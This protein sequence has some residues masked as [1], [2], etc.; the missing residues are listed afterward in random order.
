VA[1]LTTGYAG[2]INLFLSFVPRF[3][4]SV[5]QVDPSQQQ[6]QGLVLEVKLSAGAVGASRP[7]KSSLLQTLAQHPQSRSVP[8]E[9]L[10]AVA[11]LVGENEQTAIE[12]I[13]LEL[14]GG[15]R[16]QA[17]E[18]L[19]HVHWLDR[20]I[21]P[22]RGREVQHAFRSRI[23]S[24][25]SLRLKFEP[26]SHSMPLGRRTRRVAAWARAAVVT[27]IKLTRGDS[28]PIQRFKVA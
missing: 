2:P 4:H 25:T 20:Q 3:S 22:D 17:V 15:H 26:S 13:L 21:N 14:L 23:Q 9:D 5:L 12:G 7:G 6:S 1:Y 18:A 19:A 16:V 27:S 10:Q 11:A 8:E 28:R 24:V